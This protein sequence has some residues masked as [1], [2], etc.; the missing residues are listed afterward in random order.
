MRHFKTCSYYLYKIQT[1][2]R[3]NCSIFNYNSQ[4]SLYIFS[5]TLF[6]LNLL[7]SY[8]SVVLKYNNK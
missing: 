8:Y 5:V 4:P 6:Y 2:V 7:C 3:P 1:N